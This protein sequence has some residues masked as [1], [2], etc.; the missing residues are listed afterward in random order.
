M[1]MFKIIKNEP[2]YDE[3]LKRIEAL[4]E[5]E[6]LSTDE[7]DEIELLAKLVEDYEECK[8]PMDLPDPVEAI[9]FRMEQED[10]KPKDLIPC[11]GSRSKVSEVLSGKR[12][13][14]LKMI[15][16]LSSKLG[17]P[18]E[19]LLKEKGRGFSSEDCIDWLRFPITEMLKRGWF[20]GFKGTLS[21]AK[22][23]AEEL[24][25]CFAAPGGQN[26]LSP[27]LYRRSFRQGKRMDEYSL[28][29]WR[30]RVCGLAKEETNLPAYR[31]NR[32]DRKFMTGLAGLSYMSDGPLLAK[33]FLNKNGIHLILERHLQRTYLDG[34]AML[35]PDGSPIVALTIRH[36]RLDNFWFTLCHELAHIAT[37]L[38]KDGEE[39]FFDDLE[40]RADSAKEDEANKWAME[41]LIP[42]SLWDK[43]GLNAKSSL[44]EVKHFADEIKISPAIPAGRIRR[45]SGNYSL[46]PSLI[47]SKKLKPMFKLV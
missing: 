41:M 26:F 29:A 23:Q 25:T 35:M 32:I 4:M 28:A 40:T 46:F 18:A 14:S 9:K 15:R 3:Y 20:E 17:I 5:K 10:L 1:N 19:V 2:D 38:D 45:E 39:S 7:E 11:M 43:S 27:A 47:G 12:S 44:S 37:H 8:F 31:K 36:D 30:I 24:I 34:A 42:N 21:Q 22:E 6:S 13:L 33:E 16:N